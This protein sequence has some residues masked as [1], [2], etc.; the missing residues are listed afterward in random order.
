MVITR[1]KSEKTAGCPSPP[2]RFDPTEVVLEKSTPIYRVFRNTTAA[3]KFNHNSQPG[4]A[5]FS[6]FADPDVVAVLHAASD[7]ETAV[8]ETILARAFK[9]CRVRPVQYRDLVMS[10]LSPTRPLRLEDFTGPAMQRLGLREPRQLFDTP[11]NQY[12]RT[13]AWAAAA[14]T[15][16]FDGVAWTTNEASAGTAYALFGDRI[17]RSDLNH[18]HSFGMSFAEQNGT[19][20]LIDFAASCGIDVMDSEQPLP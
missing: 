14:H 12:S 17:A 6:T 11:P 19:D 7:R 2:E 8:W 1:K 4:T 20:W 13:N 3:T 5:R 9:G 18:D 15:A 16:G 10:R